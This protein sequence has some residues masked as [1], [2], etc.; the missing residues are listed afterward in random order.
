M[1]LLYQFLFFRW[2][3]TFVLS[4]YPLGIKFCVAMLL[5]NIYFSIYQEVL[6]FSVS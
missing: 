5:K 2:F 1:H 3:T 4:L 6:M